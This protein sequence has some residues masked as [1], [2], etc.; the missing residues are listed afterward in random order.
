MTMLERLHESF[1]VAA[2]E[3]PSPRAELEALQAFAAARGLRVPD[4]YLAL[5]RQATEVELLVEGRGCL[6]IWSAAGVVELNEAYGVQTAMPRALAIGDDE[7][8]NALA[9][10]E[11]SEGA[12]LYRFAFADP[13]PAEAVYLAPSLV[14]LLQHGAPFERLFDW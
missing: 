14:A 2:S 13:D 12:G 5:V 7:G 3:P 11:G 1:S 8:G 10:L 9:Y 6:R 4:E